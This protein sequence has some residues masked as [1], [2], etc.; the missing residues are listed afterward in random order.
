MSTTLIFCPHCRQF[1]QVVSLRAPVEIVVKGV[2]LSVESSVSVCRNCNRAVYDPAATVAT[3]HS[4]RK[5]YFKKLNGKTPID[6]SLV[7]V[8]SGR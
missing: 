5:S 1:V 2:S 8:F 4:V 6:M 7:R 3:H